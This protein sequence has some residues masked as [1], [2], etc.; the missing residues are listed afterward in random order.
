MDTPFGLQ[1]LEP[2][3]AADNVVGGHHTVW[4]NLKTV[5]GSTVDDID[6]TSEND[7]GGCSEE[8]PCEGG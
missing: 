8:E 2:I 4:S 1:Y 3:V 7:P 6:G 5:N